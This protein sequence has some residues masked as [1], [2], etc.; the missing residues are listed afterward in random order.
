MSVSSGR[1]SE[2]RALGLVQLLDE[3]RFP[4]KVP[5]GRFLVAFVPIVNEEKEVDAFGIVHTHACDDLAAAFLCIPS[6]ADE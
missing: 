3:S 2:A 5:L 6:F 4:G 1:Q